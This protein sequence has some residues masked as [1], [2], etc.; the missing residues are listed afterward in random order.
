MAHSQSRLTCFAL[1]SALEE[2]LRLH[3]D[4]LLVDTIP[5]KVFSDAEYQ[6]ASER[7]RRERGAVKNDSPTALLS[8]IDFADGFQ[9]LRRNRAHI[10]NDLAVQL[11]SV[12]DRLSGVVPIRNRV[13]HTRPMEI[14][15]LARMYDLCKD[16]CSGAALSNWPM[17]ANALARLENEPYYV[18]GL[19]VDLPREKD[20]APMHN[21]PIPDFEETGFYGR[22][23]QVQ[24]IKKI[25]KG[26]YPVISI[27][28]DGGIGKTAIALKVAYELLDEN[29]GFDAIVWVTAKSQNLTINEIERINGAIEDSLG[30]FMNAAK[31]LG[32]AEPEDPASEVLDYLEHFKVLL[33]LDNLETVLDARLREFLLEIPIG[34]KVIITSRIGVGVENPVSLPPLEEGEAQTLL[35][36]LAGMRDVRAL[37]GL[38]QE[39]IAGISARMGGRPAYIKWFVSG[40]QA[41]LRPEELLADNELLLDYCMSNVY[42][43][44]GDDARV[45]LRCLQVLPG[46]RTHAEI[47]FLTEMSADRTHASLLELLTTNFT[48]MRMSSGNQDTETNYEVTEFG[49]SYLDKRHRVGQDERR[50]FQERNKKLLDLGISLRAE[51]TASPFDPYTVSVQSPGDYSAARLLRESIRAARNGQFREALEGCGEAR[52]LAPSYFETW[53][54]EAFVHTFMSDY[55]SARNAYE[56][57][58]ELA[59]DYAPLYYFFGSFLIDES[60]DIEAGVSYLRKAARKNIEH[61]DVLFHVAWGSLLQ[62]RFADVLETTRH[63]LGLKLARPQG[64]AS[65]ALGLRAGVYQLRK[66]MEEGDVESALEFLELVVEFAEMTSI[67]FLPG[68]SCDRLLQL[69]ALSLELNQMLGEEFH[70]RKAA[71]FGSRLRE[72][73]RCVE[74]GLLERKLARVKTIRSDKL[75]A[76]ASIDSVDYFFHLRDLADES[77]WGHLAEGGMVSF[78]VTDTDKRGPRAT[79][80]R[81][82]D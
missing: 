54:V 39:A 42:E 72:R 82:V 46:Q 12:K 13:A 6:K 62:G 25:V 56:R 5:G 49:R 3:I 7:I 35:R 27:L 10:P 58:C 76:F 70:A 69:S 43:Y 63:V 45:V 73:I 18:L 14:D 1:I 40:I 68:E 23:K 66:I 33:I 30:L 15:D 52:R 26:A 53:R 50:V 11:E 80:V 8:Y 61:P 71:E 77:H 41:G 59:H 44:L 60:I 31:T 57:A 20:N 9:I 19:T 67:E 65:V 4:T 2:D 81:W 79:S 38:S 17:L 37:E 34:S 74:S 16:L 28:G 75:Y 51:N 55:T 48:Q 47:A 21:L 32:A 22:R 36:K 24:R 78:N 64:I 29:A